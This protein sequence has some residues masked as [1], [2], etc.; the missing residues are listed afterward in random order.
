MTTEHRLPMY[1]TPYWTISH[2]KYK[3]ILCM[4]VSRYRGI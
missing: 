1:S 4:C 2:I 3:Y